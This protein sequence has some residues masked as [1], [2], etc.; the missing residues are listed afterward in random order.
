MQ[1]QTVTGLHAFLCT[2]VK[3]QRQIFSHL[4]PEKMT[5]SM[6]RERVNNSVKWYKI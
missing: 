6:Q 2:N 5:A 4:S 3:V 1:Y